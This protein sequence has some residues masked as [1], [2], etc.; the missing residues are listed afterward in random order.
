[1]CRVLGITNFNYAKHAR[2]VARFCQLA[3]TGM[4]MAEDPPGHEDGWGLAFYRNGELVVRKSGASLL[5]E[6]DQVI[7]LLEKAR[8]SPVMI[9]HLRKSAWTNTSSTRHA[10][11]FF[12]G[13]TVFFHNGVV[14]DYQGLLPDIT[15]PGLRADARDTEVFFY[16]VMSGTTGDLG[17]DFLATAALI[18]Q[19][20]RFSA[21]NCLFSDSR[22]LFA[23]RDYTRE[24]DYYSLHKAYAENSCLVSSEPLDDN[25]RWEMMAQG[26]FLAIDPGGGG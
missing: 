22:K 1:M 26:E 21:L 2:I 4:V 6:T 7:G 19:K 20:H 18:R 23:Y 9:L 25:L 14:Y 15:L 24:P 17:R 12:L 13:D 16:H 11:P 10:H 5:D 3:R 8:T